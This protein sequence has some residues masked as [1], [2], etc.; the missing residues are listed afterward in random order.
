MPLH[1]FRQATA[2]I[3][4]TLMEGYLDK[5]HLLAMDNFYNNVKLTRFLKSRKTDVVGTLNRCRVDNPP[6]IKNL[7]DR[8]GDL[9]G[10]HC[11]D[12]T[13]M[14]WKDV[15]LVTAISTFHNIDTEAGTRA[16]ETY[17]RPLAIH[18]YNTTMGG[19]DLKDELLSMYSIERKRGTKWYIK[20]FKSI[21]NISV[22]NS[23][24]IHR[25]NSRSSNRKSYTHRKFRYVL[26]TELAQQLNLSYHTTTAHE[27]PI[28]SSRLDRIDHW[29]GQ[30]ESTERTNKSKVRFKRGR[31]VQ[32]L[33]NN[34]HYHTIQNV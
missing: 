26:A 4:L 16:G 12:V 19:V 9:V 14:A 21:I 11:G 33:K 28:D 27:N 6:A 15:K 20:L 13:V 24:I 22:L 17:Q 8:L 5:G 7:N 2:K 34:K 32:C 29:P 1:G 30:V 3:V 25:A 23:Y 18:T 10:F 31:C